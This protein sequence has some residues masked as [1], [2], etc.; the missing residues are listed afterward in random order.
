MACFADINVS[1]GSVAT[2]A[3]CG[4]MFNV[5]LTVNLLRNLPVKK[6]SKSV[7]IWQTYARMVESVAPFFGAPCI[8]NS[9]FADSLSYLRYRLLS[10]LICTSNV[11]YLFSLIP[12]IWLGLKIYK[13]QLLQMDPRYVLPADA[14]CCTQ[15][16][17]LTLNSNRPPDPTMC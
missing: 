6:F 16:L 15:R 3:R 1:Q 14:S 10:I 8:S 12:M 17:T 11:K 5:L 4:G 2:Y 9:D 13:Y 7:K